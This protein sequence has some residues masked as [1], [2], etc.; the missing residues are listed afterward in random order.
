M[1]AKLAYGCEQFYDALRDARVA[2]GLE[3]EIVQT[4]LE[5][6]VVVE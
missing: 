3:Y 1:A 6:I 2:P 5:A 4:R